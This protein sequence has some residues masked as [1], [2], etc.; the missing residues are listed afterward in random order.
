MSTPLEQPWEDVTIELLYFDGLKKESR[1][2]HLLRADVEGQEREHYEEGP[3]YV[4]SPEEFQRRILTNVE[5]MVVS[6]LRV[7]GEKPHQFKILPPSAVLEVRV[8]VNN[9]EPRIVTLS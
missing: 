1:T 9:V 2:I 3:D 7:L 5:G 4:L 6:P 8:S